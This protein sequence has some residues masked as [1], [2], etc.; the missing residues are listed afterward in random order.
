MIYCC[1]A[2]GRAALTAEN[3]EVAEGHAS[4]RLDGER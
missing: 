3:A 4:T 2:T 1:V